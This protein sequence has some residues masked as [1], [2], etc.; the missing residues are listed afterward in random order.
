ML[1]FIRVSISFV[2]IDYYCSFLKDA[3]ESEV[4]AVQWNPMCRTLA[5][6]GLDKKVKLW[7]LSEGQ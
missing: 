2:K 4:D 6:G 3:H 7:D 1:I 5:T